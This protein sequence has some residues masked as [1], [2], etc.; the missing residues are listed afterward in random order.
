MNAE[1]DR[2]RDWKDSA[3]NRERKREREDFFMLN[4]DMKVNFYPHKSL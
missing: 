2:G 1:K 3:T 4:I